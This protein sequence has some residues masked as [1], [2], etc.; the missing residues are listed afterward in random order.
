MPA[1]PKFYTRDV[2]DPFSP[3]HALTQP[4]AKPL[5]SQAPEDI[6]RL[7]WRVESPLE[8]SAAIAACRERAKRGKLAE[9]EVGAGGS[10]FAVEAAATPFDHQLVGDLKQT[11]GGSVAELRLVRL[12]RMPIVFAVVLAITVWPGV[13]LTDS[14]LVTYFTWY[15]RWVQDMPWL[16][17]AWYLPLTALPLPWVWAGCV[18]KSRIEAVES[19]HEMARAVAR[20]ME[21]SVVEAPPR[22]EASAS[23]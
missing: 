14:M 21:G 2:A 6:R 22:N 7:R 1:E 4:S 12:K 17:Y 10:W 20:A 18:R 5:A 23:E 8:P 3:E 13:W 11:Q 9:F 15:S 16:T 19:A